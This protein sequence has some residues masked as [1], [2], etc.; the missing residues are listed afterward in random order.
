MMS[1]GGSADIFGVGGVSEEAGGA[2][3]DCFR[4]RTSCST[5]R[6]CTPD[7]SAI[8]YSRGASSNPTRLCMPRD[9]GAGAPRLRC[10]CCGASAPTRAG[11][12]RL[13]GTPCSNGTG[14]GAPPCRSALR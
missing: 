5:V 2:G 8:G 11:S 12:W 4:A 6:D 7:A 13:R 10:E 1:A 9:C 3:E 14:A